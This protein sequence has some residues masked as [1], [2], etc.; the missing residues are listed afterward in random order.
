MPTN[1][2]PNMLSESLDV[3]GSDTIN[4]N[5][6][7]SDEAS[8]LGSVV[9][10][11]S[12]AT[13]ASNVGSAVTLTGGSSFTADSVGNFISI[14]G[15]STSGN[16]GTFPI[17]QFISG[18]SVVFTNS[19]ISLPDASSISWIQRLPYSLQDDINFERTDRQL[20]KGVGFSAQIPIYNRPTATTTDLPTDLAHIA[21][22]TTDARGF[23][24]NRKFYNVPVHP[25]DQQ[26]EVVDAGNL[27]HSDAIDKTGIP[28][29]NVGPYS[30]NTIA[31]FVDVSDG[32]T[33][34]EVL[35]SGGLHAGEKIFGLTESTL[36]ASPDSI[37][38]V[39]FSCPIGMNPS[40][41]SSPYTWEAGL[42]NRLTCIYGFFQRL[43][44]L[45]DESLRTSLS[46]GGGGATSTTTPSITFLHSFLFGGM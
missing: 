5:R 23:I 31:C 11:G 40:T 19:A 44:L 3:A 16:N 30:G 2:N 6:S 10:G 36:S 15:S 8:G 38:I 22:K 25:G 42:T 13:L 1:S 34:G 32:Y 12:G 24:A 20:I 37:D 18:S 29:F 14:G 33:D 9:S 7:L 21:G 45:S 43:D 28:C 39:F 17:T 26:V 35:V 4:A 41:S 46:S 27:K